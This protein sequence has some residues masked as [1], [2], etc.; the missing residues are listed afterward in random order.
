MIPHHAGAIL[1]RG[2]AEPKGPEIKKLCAGIIASQQAEID[3]MK[4]L[5][6]GGGLTPASVEYLDQ[7]VDLRLA[8]AG[9]SGVEGMCHAMPQVIAKRLLLHLVEGRPHC[10]HLSQD[11]NAV[12]VFLD[13]AGNASHLALDTA[14]PSELGFLDFG[15]HA[16][17]DTPAGYK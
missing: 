4:G 14:E 5:L 8:V 13:H 2:K 9:R 3:Q 11:I 12:A 1:M 10:P 6:R 15:V 16:L 7:F 17:K